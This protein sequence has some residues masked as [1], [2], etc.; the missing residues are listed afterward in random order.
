M[1]SRSGSRV[2]CL[3]RRKASIY[4]HPVHP[5]IP[6][7]GQTVHGREVPGTAYFLTSYP[8]KQPHTPAQGAASSTAA[9]NEARRVSEA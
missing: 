7:P 1:E 8:P 3:H 5:P 6:G 2:P 9:A 4:N